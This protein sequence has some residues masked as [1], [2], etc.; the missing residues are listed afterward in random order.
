MAVDIQDPTN[1]GHKEEAPV[2]GAE[3]VAAGVTAG[4]E[5]APIS[6][7]ISTKLA[8]AGQTG[9]ALKQFTGLTHLEYKNGLPVISFEEYVK[10]YNTDI[11]A[12]G[13]HGAAT[14]NF[15]G[16]VRYKQDDDTRESY[17]D[18]LATNGILKGKDHNGI[19][20]GTDGIVG[21]SD[22]EENRCMEG[23]EDV[24]EYDVY[25]RIPTALQR[26]QLV[27]V[28]C[29]RCQPASEHDNPEAAYRRQEEVAR[30]FKILCKDGIPTSD[31]VI[32]LWANP[33][34]D[35]LAR[36]KAEIIHMKI[37][38]HIETGKPLYE[39]RD[40]VSDLE[41]KLQNLSEEGLN[42]EYPLLG[43]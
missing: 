10:M 6:D 18:S 2:F 16:Y 14:F 5:I 21:Y 36:R 35:K 27:V 23:P 40:M 26:E 43:R 11:R 29:D 25:I 42:R 41:D 30:K 22:Y 39:I 17:K 1:D 13:D 4:N 32:R 19:H 33:R 28:D 34:R 8:K 15:Q 31:I 20:V 37:V 7:R 3:M 38:Q 9:T 12:L 24:G